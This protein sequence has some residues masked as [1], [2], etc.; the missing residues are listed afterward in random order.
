MRDELR[1]GIRV[2]AIGYGTEGFEA[3]EKG[4]DKGSPYWAGD[5]LYADHT[6]EV[7]HTALNGPQQGWALQLLAPSVIWAVAGSKSASDTSKA[8]GDQFNLGGTLVLRG[9]EVLFHHS[10]SNYADHPDL[11]KLIMLANSAHSTA[12]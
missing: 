5:N 6:K 4:D 11:K 3:F 10:Q 2:C 9:D 12:D 8:G 1:D 7:F